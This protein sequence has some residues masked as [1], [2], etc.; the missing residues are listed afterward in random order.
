LLSAEIVVVLIQRRVCF[1]VD[2]VEVWKRFS[3]LDGRSIAANTSW[4]HDQGKVWEEYVVS[5]RNCSRFVL[6]SIDNWWWYMLAVYNW[7]WLIIEFLITMMYMYGLW[8]SHDA[9]KP[10]TSILHGVAHRSSPGPYFGNRLYTNA[11]NETPHTSTSQHEMATH[12]R[13]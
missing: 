13:K 8:V 3:E 7:K 1:E 12:I 11:H 6:Q 4:L 5:Q 9:T 2:V 10:Y